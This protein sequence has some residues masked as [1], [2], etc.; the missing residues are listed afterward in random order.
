MDKKPKSAGEI[1]KEARE[2][3]GLSVDNI[4]EQTGIAKS[5]IENLEAS[6]YQFLPAK[7]YVIGFIKKYAEVLGIDEAPVIAE[8]EKELIGLKLEDK[9]VKLPSLDE[10]NKFLKPKKIITG[11]ILLLLVIVLMF[12]LKQIFYVFKGPDIFLLSP[13]KD[14]MTDFGKLN[15]SG[16]T[17]YGTELIINGEH[18]YVDKSGNFA[19]EVI[20]T[21]GFNSIRVFAK[22]KFGKTAEVVRSVIYTPVIENPA[23]SEPLPEGR[24]E[25]EIK[26]AANETENIMP[27]QE[28]PQE[29]SSDIIE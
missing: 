21:E 23:N 10:K 16:R 7:V 11:L 26:N 2:K 25:A 18:V 4:V 28:L 22:N 1:L 20:L 12:F 6:A 17:N 27:S 14:F 9:I 15:V 29:G 24:Q 8:Y 19:K 13:S 5:Q 3:L